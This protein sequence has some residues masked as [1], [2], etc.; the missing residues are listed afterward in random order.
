MFGLSPDQQG[1]L[2]QAAHASLVL[3]IAMALAWLYRHR[4]FIRGIFKR[5]LRHL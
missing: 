5:A 3:S 2:I 4:H 1:F